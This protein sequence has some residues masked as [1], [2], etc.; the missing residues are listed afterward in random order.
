MADPIYLTAPRATTFADGIE[1]QDFV[2]AELGK[3]GIILQNFASRKYQFAVG[4]NI[5]GWEIKL[6]ERCTETGRLSIEIAEKSRST[7]P[8]W[9][10]SGIYRKDNTWLYIQG[11]C[12]LLFIFSKAWLQRYHR[13]KKPPIEESH[14][15][16]RKFYLPLPIARLCAVRV[17]AL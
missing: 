7:M 11:N 14:G 16:V 13:V 9:T 8:D 12:S 2:C 5:Q 10:P 17:L 1:F 6:D 15:T 4:E 3:Q